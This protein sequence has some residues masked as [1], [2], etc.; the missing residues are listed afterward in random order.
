MRKDW[1]SCDRIADL[2]VCHLQGGQAQ[3]LLIRRLHSVI[4]NIA[5]L[6]HSEIA[7]IHRLG[8]DNRHQAVLVSDMLGVSRLKW[9]Q[10][11]KKM[12]L[13]IDKPENIS[14]IAKRHLVIE[15]VLLHLISVGLRTVPSKSFALYVVFQIFKLY[16]A[17]FTIRRQPLVMQFIHQGFKLGFKRLP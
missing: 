4:G 13:F 9:C 7:V 10:G 6:S 1:K 8:K 12:T 15:S 14:D 16:L 2:I 5:G 17:Q 11:C 3:I